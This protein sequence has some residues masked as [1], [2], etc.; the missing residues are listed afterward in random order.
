MRRF[1]PLQGGKKGLDTCVNWRAELTGKQRQT[2]FYFK[3]DLNC[4]KTVYT[5]VNTQK[6]KTPLP[7]ICLA[8]PIRFHC[9]F[10]VTKMF[11]FAMNGFAINLPIEGKESFLKFNCGLTSIISPKYLNV[12]RLKTCMFFFQA[13]HK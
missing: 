13:S 4:H 1:P 7:F 8:W 11:K 6:I 5:V 10:D 12:Q 2:F 9:L 3:D